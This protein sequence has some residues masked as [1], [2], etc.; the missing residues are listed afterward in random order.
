VIL[1]DEPVVVA[2]VIFDAMMAELVS[3]REDRC[4]DDVFGFDWDAECSEWP[5]PWEWE[6]RTPLRGFMTVLSGR[7]DVTA[8]TL[9]A[10][11]ELGSLL[12]DSSA[13]QRLLSA[14]GED[15][16]DQLPAAAPPAVSADGVQGSSIS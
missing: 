7:S 2:P 9:E 10:A 14:L 1:V 11:R 8:W 6:W 4:W 12:E 16:M 13:E 5:A 3:V 15:V